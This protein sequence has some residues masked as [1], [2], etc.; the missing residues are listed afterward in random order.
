[1]LAKHFIRMTLTSGFCEGTKSCA[2]TG[3]SNSD[4]VVS[5]LVGSVKT[6]CFARSFVTFKIRCRLDYILPFVDTFAGKNAVLQ[7]IRLARQLSHAVCGLSWWLD[8]FWNVWQAFQTFSQHVNTGL[9]WAREGI[10][11]TLDSLGGWDQK[12][13]VFTWIYLLFYLCICTVS[14]ITA[15]NS[16]L[17]VDHDHFLKSLK[18]S[19][20]VPN[21]LLF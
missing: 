10:G 6:L 3:S 5:S 19:Y 15:I 14:D 1:M 17:R 20:C 4:R 13:K 18:E 11:L 2:V 7:P 21:L 12:D 16:T 9:A 8:Q